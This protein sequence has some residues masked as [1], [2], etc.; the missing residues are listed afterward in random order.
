MYATTFSVDLASKVLQV[1]GDDR[2]HQRVSQQRSSR[3]RFRAWSEGWPAGPRVAMV[4][5]NKT[6]ANDAEVIFEAALRPTLK[7][8]PVQT[9]EQQAILAE[10]R[11]REGLLR[12]RTRTRNQIRGLLQEFGILIT[13]RA[14]PFRR[15][16]ASV[17]EAAG[18]GLP[19]RWRTLPK[20]PMPL[21]GGPVQRLPTLHPCT[22]GRTGCG[23]R[24]YSSSG[25]RMPPSE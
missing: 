3:A 11:S 25:S 20:A 24:P 4:L 9:A 21:H 8:V 6:D 13:A 22:T 14:G 5:G 15:Q 17:R 1:R 12:D 18:N 7:P 19:W 16:V 10:H 2:Q 23:N